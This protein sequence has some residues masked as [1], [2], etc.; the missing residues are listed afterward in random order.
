[1]RLFAIGLA[2]V[3]LLPQRD[4]PL[5]ALAQLA[6][7]RAPLVVSLPADV[8]TNR[9]VVHYFLIGPFGGLG[10]FARRNPK[11]QNFQIETETRGV[12][13]QSLR[14]YVHCRGYQ[15]ELLDFPFLG[16]RPRS[17]VKL[18]PIPLRTIPLAGVVVGLD[19]GT[20]ALEVE[21]QY[22]PWWMCEFFRL[23][24]CG[25]G[26][27]YIAHAELGADGRFLVAIPDFLRDPAISSFKLR[28]ELKFL[29]RG[30]SSGNIVYRLRSTFA[31]SRSGRIQER[32]LYPDEHCMDESH[33]G[34]NRSASR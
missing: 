28:G 5:D 32:A 2:G 33:A 16:D 30:R 25:L 20:A 6:P 4:A 10:G 22:Y 1:M 3:L 8:D 7:V 23:A 31:E 9:C 18:T 27:R 21:V 11:S 26:G 13:G 24:D 34:A 15:L 19:R 14:A 29:I 12:P 17:T